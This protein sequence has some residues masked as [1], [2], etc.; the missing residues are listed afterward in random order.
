V[1]DYRER[2]A[3][4]WWWWL[5]VVGV[6]AV[7]GAEL[8]TGVDLVWDLS[9][10]AA[11]GVAAVALLAGLGRTRIEVSGVT[12]TAGRARI[13]VRMLGAP[14]VLDP[15]LLRHQIGPEAD[16]TAYLMVRWWV[17]QAVRLDVLDPDDDTPYWIVSTRHPMELAAAVE[18]AKAREAAGRP[19]DAPAA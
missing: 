19:Q 6:V 10:F 12:L 8:Y 18:A 7:L 5:A 11:V 15:D 3:T 17:R 16:P 14:L 2:L 1:S 9:G 13:P 4:P